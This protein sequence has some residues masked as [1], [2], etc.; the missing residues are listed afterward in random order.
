MDSQSVPNSQE[1]GENFRRNLIFLHLGIKENVLIDAWAKF[2][3][4]YCHHH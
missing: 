1:L 3:P 4:G 2:T